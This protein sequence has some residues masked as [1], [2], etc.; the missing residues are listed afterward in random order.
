MLSLRF[1]CR[2]TPQPA[3]PAVRARLRGGVMGAR[4]SGMVAR[5]GAASAVAKSMNPECSGFDP[6]GG[7]G[8]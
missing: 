2:L 6:G 5:H 3:L 1:T 7:H 8:T 4:F